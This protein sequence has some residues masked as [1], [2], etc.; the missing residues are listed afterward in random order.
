MTCNSEN[1]IYCITCIGITELVNENLHNI[2]V[3]QN[4]EQW[5]GFVNIDI[6]FILSSDKT[7]GQYFL[8]SGHKIAY[9]QM[10]PFEE[11]RSKT[12]HI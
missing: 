7:I 2:L 10:I 8:S 6:W 12:S 5:K 11:I 1:V 9:L 3:I 4:V